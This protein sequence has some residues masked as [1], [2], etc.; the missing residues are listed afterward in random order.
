MILFINAEPLGDERDIV[1]EYITATNKLSF[2]LML[3]LCWRC[4]SFD[5][6]FLHGSLILSGPWYQ[7]RQCMLSVDASITQICPL[8]M[9]S[10]FFHHGNLKVG[11]LLQA[12]KLAPVIRQCPANLRF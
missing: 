5:K 6:P 10:G 1:K 9:V 7:Y 12:C 11:S 8:A 2:V 4:V 3:Q